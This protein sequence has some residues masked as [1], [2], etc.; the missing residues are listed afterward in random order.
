MRNPSAVS[1]YAAP[2]HPVRENTSIFEM[3]IV[4]LHRLM[5]S[6]RIEKNVNSM[7]EN[8]L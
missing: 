4:N 7:R 6:S 8:L 1:A 2:A 5:K 3:Q